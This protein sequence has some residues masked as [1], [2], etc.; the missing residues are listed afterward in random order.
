MAD[1]KRRSFFN[2][3][4]WGEDFFGGDMFEQF[5]Q[6]EER[7]RR[8]M[9]GIS[10]GDV[11]AGEPIVYGFN[12]SVGQ[13]GK[14]VMQEFGNVKPTTKGAEVSDKR[15]P[16]VDVIEHDADITVIAEIPGVE[17]SD[18]RLNVDGDYL[19]ISVTG[20]EQK[21]FKRA[22]LPAEVKPET[23]KATYKNG[24]LEVRLERKRARKAEPSSSIKVD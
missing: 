3:D 24:V 16:L 11:K 12:F 5:A 17:K 21:Y 20:G 1:K 23:A 4:I 7:M 8:M 10:E 19:V 13:D 18:I 14:P 9:H 22:K 2:D 15:E 6:I